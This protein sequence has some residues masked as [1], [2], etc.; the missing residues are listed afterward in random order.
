[1][2]ASLGRIKGEKSR[3]AEAAAFADSYD[4][5]AKAKQVAYE[6]LAHKLEEVTQAQ[7]NQMPTGVI[8][9]RAV[10]P[11][12][13]TFPNIPLFAALGLVL[14]MLVGFA[15]ILVRELFN[16]NV[17]FA[18]DLT[19][20][21]GA[22]F[23]VS[24]PKMT[25]KMLGR[26]GANLALAD[27]ILARPVSAYSEAFRTI[28]STILLNQPKPPQLIAVVSALPSEGKST[29]ATSLARIMAANNDKV[30]IVDCDLRRGTV[31][32]IA[33]ID[34]AVGLV[35]VLNGKTSWRDAVITHTESGL[36]MLPVASTRFTTSDLFSGK[37][38]HD[39]IE[40][41][42]AEYQFVIL[43]TPP[44]LAVSDSRV[45]A[46]Q[47]DATRTTRLTMNPRPDYAECRCRYS[48][49]QRQVGCA[50]HRR[51]IL[52]QERGC[53]RSRQCADL[54]CAIRADRSG[55]AGWL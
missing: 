12:L 31:A 48:S 23:I 37:A 33:G 16:P 35:E 40:Q 54:C 9:E 38:M 24:V 22:H 20:A 6:E 51:A 32:K 42:R 43:D 5:D 47:A 17:R 34:P 7:H 27:L 39:L 26:G 15:T 28:R 10:T 50:R 29:V 45:I 1:M 36:D 2:R 19:S 41:L 3:N 14:G 11:S 52:E 44:V 21:T 25:K 4:R 30:I 18:E 53:R 46:S 13:P 55:I 8:V 49:R